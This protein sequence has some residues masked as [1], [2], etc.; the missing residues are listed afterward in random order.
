M[1]SSV[2]ARLV[3]AGLLPG[4]LGAC[5]TYHPIVAAAPRPSTRVSVVLNDYGR[6]E[7]SRQIGPGVARVEGAVLA[8][9]DTAYVLGVSGVKAVSG[10]WARWSGEEV[11]MRRDYVALLY[12]RRL[13]RGR[14]AVFLGSVAVAVVTAMVRFNIL[15]FGGESVPIIP[16]PGDP[17]DQ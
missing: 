9:S 10:G 1:R 11:S 2:T 7:A 15:G 13:S 17:G 5:Y 8:S 14:T 12:E 4:L 3:A 16:N 6:L